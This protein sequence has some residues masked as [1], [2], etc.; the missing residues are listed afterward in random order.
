MSVFH[1]SEG[2]LSTKLPAYFGVSNR[3]SFVFCN[4]ESMRLGMMVVR[5]NRQICD[6]ID[7]VVRDRL[8]VTYVVRMFFP[9]HTE[10]LSLPVRV[11]WVEGGLIGLQ[12]GRLGPTV[13]RALVELLQTRPVVRVEESPMPMVG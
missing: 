8:P 13:T 3:S 2:M 1:T 12:M 4:V 7:E 11:H 6:F 9:S 5:A 10:P